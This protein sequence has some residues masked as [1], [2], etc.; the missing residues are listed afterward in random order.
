MLA[1]MIRYNS[2]KQMTIGEFKTP[3][4]ARMDK[5]NR[6]VK[7][8]ESL[9]WDSLADIYYKS[10]SKKMGTPT[11][12][13]RIVIGAMVIKHLLK[14]DNRETI[15]TI[16]ENPYMQYFLGLSQYTHEDVF[17][18]SLFTRWVCP[19]ECIKLGCLQ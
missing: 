8:A 14:L 12:D 4:Q 11:I 2:Q 3:F 10:M 13:G 16:R 18:R 6:W 19:V 5:G 1:D 9:P 7:L 17:D 15:E